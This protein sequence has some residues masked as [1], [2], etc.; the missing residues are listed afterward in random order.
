MRAGSGATREDLCNDD[1]CKSCAVPD[2]DPEFQK[3]HLRFNNLE[4]AIRSWPHSEH[5]PELGFLQRPRSPC[6]LL[7]H[8]L[9]DPALR[10][11]LPPGYRTQGKVINSP[12]DSVLG[13]R[14]SLTVASAGDA[15][16][17]RGAAFLDRCHE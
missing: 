16:R 11:A 4:Q 12:H 3:H 9:R 1:R 7:G 15:K 13:G 14:A 2:E 10:A 6:G 8:G 17:S 5:A